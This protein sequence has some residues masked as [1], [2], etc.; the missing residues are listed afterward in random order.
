MLEICCGLIPSC[1]HSPEFRSHA[2][3]SLG[4]L[5]AWSCCQLAASPSPLCPRFHRTSPTLLCPCSCGASCA[6]HSHRIQQNPEKLQSQAPHILF[7]PDTNALRHSFL[8][9]Q[10][11][12]LPAGTRTQRSKCFKYS[13]PH[14]PPFGIKAVPSGKS[15]CVLKQP[16][17]TV[18]R[19]AHT[20]SLLPLLHP[21]PHLL[22]GFVPHVQSGL[23]H[24]FWEETSLWLNCLNTSVGIQSQSALHLAVFGL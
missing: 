13:S 3:P 11:V 23:D 5:C 18:W 8:Q 14:A 16:Q 15:T 20:Q 21:Y 9:G 10:I 7:D 19:G 6:T 12:T 17:T 1:A 24:H 4:A 2:A 22:A